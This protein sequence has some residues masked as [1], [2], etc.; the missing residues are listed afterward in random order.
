[1]ADLTPVTDADMAPPPSLTPV[2]DADMAPNEPVR[3][4]KGGPSYPPA[5]L[6]RLAKGDAVTRIL[7]KTVEG[8]ATGAGMFAST[9]AQWASE[10]K[11]LDDAGLGINQPYTPGGMLRTFNRSLAAGL[12][13]GGELLKQTYGGMLGAVK[14]AVQGTGEEL[15]LPNAEGAGNSAA[16]YLDAELSKGGPGVHMTAPV[17]TAMGTLVDR[18][19]GPLPRPEEVAGQAQTVANAVHLPNAAPAVEALYN[20]KGILPAEVLN[21]AKSNPAVMQHLAGGPDPYPTSDWTGQAIEPPGKPAGEP[22]QTPA[23][24]TPSKA[25]EAPQSVPA[26]PGVSKIGQSINQKAIDAKLTE[27]FAQTA[28]YDKVTIADQAAQ[29]TQL[30]NGDLDKARAI[31]RGEEP[32]PGNLKGVSLVTAMEEH[33]KQNPNGDLAYELA[34]SPLVSATSGAAQE[35]RLAAE[36]T[37][38]SATAALQQIKDA[39]VKQAGGPAE[40]ATRAKA[41]KAA[42]PESTGVLLPKEELSWERFLEGIQ[43]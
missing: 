36:R 39:T 29:A 33:I 8:A 11:A 26:E 7:Q 17:R 19:I 32:L 6:G 13:V 16:G 23:T 5:V 27:G 12:Q 2:T 25:P 35:L 40:V 3:G 4:V 9:D 10:A 15:G 31:I 24:E 18:V 37:P 28:L 1:M 41:V 38:D 20:D 14:G 22:G 43:C 42:L 34:N 30:V 21:D